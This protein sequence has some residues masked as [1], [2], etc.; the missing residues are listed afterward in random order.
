[1]YVNCDIIYILLK[2]L[3]YDL[4]VYH[5]HSC[6]NA[7]LADIKARL[8]TMNCNVDT[9]EWES[10]TELLLNKLLVS[11][12]ICQVNADYC[13]LTILISLIEFR[14]VFDCCPDVHGGCGTT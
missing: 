8:R 7:L 6:M 9:R 1:M 10:Q 2:G 4:Q 11:Y 5:P 12:V 13:C 3:G 14:I